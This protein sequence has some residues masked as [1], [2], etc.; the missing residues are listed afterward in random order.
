LPMIE[1][2]EA[3]LGPT[4]WE[5]IFVDDDSRDGTADEARR[6]A[7]VDP[8]VR[9][10]QRIGRR[11]LASAAIEGICATA[12]PVVAVMDADLQH[13]PALLPEMIS[14]IPDGESRS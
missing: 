10:I 14:A 12:A 3:A 4:G 9:V 2:I 6:L 8:R 13:D 1:R 7:A 11:G 5:A